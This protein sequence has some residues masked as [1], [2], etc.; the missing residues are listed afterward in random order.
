MADKEHEFKLSIP[1]NPERGCPSGFHK[2]S[3][4]KTDSGKVVPARCVRATTTYKETSKEFKSKQKARMTRRIRLHIP[5]IRTLSR[6]D[7][8]PGYIPRKAYVRRYS[9]AVRAK[10]FTVKRSSGRVYRVYPKTKNAL[11]DSRCV[12]DLG[13]PGKGRDLERGLRLS[14]RVSWQS[15]D[16]PSGKRRL[17]AMRL[18]ERRPVSLAHSVSIGS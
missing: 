7:C 6:K 3:E 16:I 14:E 9:T 4:Y 2:R 13:L 11:V 5:S 8:P 1:Y 18:S 15:T 12:K 17:C 10:G